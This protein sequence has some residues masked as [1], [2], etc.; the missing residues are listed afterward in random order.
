MYA[1]CVKCCLLWNV[2]IF[3]KFQRQAI[4]VPGAGNQKPGSQAVPEKSG[5][6]G[7]KT[8]PVCCI[9]SPGSVMRRYSCVP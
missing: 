9:D 5:G 2:S 3:Q 1:K 8:C 4:S 6:S 7:S